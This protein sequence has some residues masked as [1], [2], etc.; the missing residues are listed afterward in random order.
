MSVDFT[1]YCY[2]CGGKNTLNLPAPNA[3]AYHHQDL[4]CNNCGDGTRVLVSHCPNCSN[5]YVYWIDDLHI[6]N[7]VQGFAKYMVHNMQAMID[8]AAQQGARISIDTPEKFPINAACP[9]GAKFSIDIE[10]P[11][12]D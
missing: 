6:P 3:P 11:D 8:K 9:C 5:Q 12:L 7:L 10:I 1:Y 4:T 2:R